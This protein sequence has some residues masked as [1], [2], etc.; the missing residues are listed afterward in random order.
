MSPFLS[1]DL[2]L[3]IIKKA[4]GQDYQYCYKLTKINMIGYFT[5]YWGMETGKIS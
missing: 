5:K 2:K 1:M 3:I 4:T